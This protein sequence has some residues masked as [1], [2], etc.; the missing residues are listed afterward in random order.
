MLLAFTKEDHTLSPKDVAERTGIPVP[1]LYR[2]LSMLRQ[3]GL[4]VGDGQGRYHLSSRFSALARA[5]EAADAMT[6]LADPTMRELARTTGETVLLVRLSDRVPLCVHRIES[7]H[8]L[9]FAFD[10][11]DAI[12]LERGASARVLIGALSAEERETLLCEVRHQDPDGFPALLRRFE[13]AGRDGWATA[14]EELD[15]GIWAAS[16]AVH[17]EHGEVCAALTLTVPV[18]RVT[19]ATEGDLVS[20]LRAAAKELSG[21]LAA[22]AGGLERRHRS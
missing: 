20:Q 18:V 7:S 11:G 3:T 9:R 6:A 10:P 12:P 16:A 5:A 8:R 19:P 17:D 15:A 4:L 1:S 22:G 13:D 14:T 21:R 2:Y